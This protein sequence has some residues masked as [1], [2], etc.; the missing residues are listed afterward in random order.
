MYSAS[1]RNS[2]AHHGSVTI[3][4]R[5]GETSKMEPASTITYEHILSVIVTRM[6]RKNDLRVL[7]AG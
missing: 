2:P 6:K 5:F 4:K 1:S 3:S 7:D